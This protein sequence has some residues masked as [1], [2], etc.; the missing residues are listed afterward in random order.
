[1]IKKLIGS[2][3]SF[4]TIFIPKSEF[5]KEPKKIEKP[6]TQYVGVP[7]PVVLSDDSWFGAATKTEKAIEYVQ[8]KNEELYKKL[9]SQPKPKEPENIH[10]VMYEK[11][12]KNIATT[13][14]LNPIGGSENFQGGSENFHER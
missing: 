4:R 1:M 7:A 14:A 9:E 10:H 2:L 3:K 13:L 12:T 11:A 5:V 6:K 8:K